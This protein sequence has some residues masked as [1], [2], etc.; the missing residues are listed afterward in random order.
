MTVHLKVADHVATV[1]L[2]RPEVMNAIDL[3]TEAELQRV[4]NELEQR[5]DVRVIVLTGE[6]E[7]AFCVGAD[8]KNPSVKGVDYWAAAR[9]GGFGGIAMRESLNIPLI[10]R[11]NGYALGGG[12]EMVLGCD[13]VVACEDASFGLPEPLVGR[14]PLDGGMTLL[15]RQIPHRLAMGLLLTGQRIKAGRALEI[16]LINEV[17]PRAELDAAVA[18]WVAQILACAPLSV[19]AIKQ[20]VRLTGSMPPAQAQALRLPALVAALQSEDADEGVRAFQE[21]RKPQWKGC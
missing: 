20:V 11:V 16:G 7:R 19:Q 12:F 15:Q 18:R 6:G 2:A 17:V 1:T 9:P 21:K 4:W 13:I 3:A 10:A 5:R 14:M 8:M